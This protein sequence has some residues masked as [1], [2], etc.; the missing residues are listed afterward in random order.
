[1]AAG[2]GRSI[3]LITGHNRDEFRLFT[4]LSGRRGQITEA[5]ASHV[6][7]S[8]APAAADGEAACREAYPDVDAETL[9]ELVQS[10]WLFRM[11]TL[12]FAQAH[13]AAGGRTFLYEVSYPALAGQGA[14]HALDMPLVFGVYLG[15]GRMLFGP[16]PPASAIRL[17][18]LMRRQWTAFAADGD[19][20]W[21]PYAP[22]HLTTR[23]F[24][25][26]PDVAPYP[27]TASLHAWDQ[28]RF[29]VLELTPA[30]GPGVGAD[31]EPV[32]EHAVGLA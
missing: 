26:P 23:I 6:L 18:D 11:P 17:G 25:D 9:F 7:R 8:L 13:A 12:H 28:H 29:G 32:P 24:D 22:G 19:P 21:P 20:G 3:D 4:E 31:P 16:K 5:E 14:C 10:D 2:A 27:E 15:L 1:M 30:P